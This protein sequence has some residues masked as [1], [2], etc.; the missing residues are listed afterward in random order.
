[1]VTSYS[2]LV[3]VLMSL[4]DLSL[5]LINK[6]ITVVEYKLRSL[7]EQMRGE[8]GRIQYKQSKENTRGDFALVTTHTKTCIY[9]QNIKNAAQ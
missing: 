1:M 2:Y 8:R 3:F 5:K 7:V 4:M 6:D 9:M